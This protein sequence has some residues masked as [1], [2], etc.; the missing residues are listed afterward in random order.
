MARRA[1]GAGERRSVRQGGAGGRAIGVRRSRALSREYDELIGGMAWFLI[2]S[3]PGE[4]LH[5]PRFL[6]QDFVG[7]GR[8]GPRVTVRTAASHSGRERESVPTSTD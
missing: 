5:Q 6:E 8:S 7:E 1:D 2:G 3:G 4:R